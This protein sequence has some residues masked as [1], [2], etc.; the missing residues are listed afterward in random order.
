MRYEM[1]LVAFDM[2]DQVH[3]ALTVR[4]TSLE[5]PEQR[6]SAVNVVD[7]VQGVGESDPRQWARDVLVAML[8]DL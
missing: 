6:E 8:E 5:Y 4:D 3:L 2:L 7:D 1:H